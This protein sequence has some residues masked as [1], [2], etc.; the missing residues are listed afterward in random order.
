MF[1]RRIRLIALLLVVST[2]TAQMPISAFGAEEKPTVAVVSEQQ[3]E[4]APVQAEDI[5]IIKETRMSRWVWVILG[6]L[7]AGG[8]AAAFS[9]G[10]GG[11]SGS[12]TG[13][14]TVNW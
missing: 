3:P 10:G 13:T 6:V 4:Q 9:G 1:N 11:G 8:A 5:P 2:V 7:V 14:T 12:T